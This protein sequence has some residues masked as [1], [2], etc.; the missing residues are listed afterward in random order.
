MPGSIR[1][2]IAGRRPSASTRAR[3]AAVSAAHRS[4]VA[5]GQLRRFLRLPLGVQLLG[6]AVAGV[7]AVLR[8]QALG[9]R[10][11][12]AR[13]RSI[14]R[15]GPNGPR[16]AQPAS[17]RALVPVEPQPVE[18]ARG[19]PLE[20]ERGAGHV[21]VLQAEDEGP[22]GVPGEQVVEER[23]PGGP[24]VE[25]PGGARARCG[26]AEWSCARLYGCH[27]GRPVTG[28]RG[29]PPCLR[30]RGPSAG[31][32]PAGNPVE[33][34]RVGLAAE[35]ADER[36]RP[37]AERRPPDRPVERHRVQRC[38]AGQDRRCELPASGARASRYDRSAGSSSAV[39][40]IR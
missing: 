9:G 20:L 35:D 12:R 1:N 34:R 13:R 38:G 17:G 11:R 25:R 32:K 14:W 5:R 22:A 40:V 15:Y 33:E 18:A 4:D 8:E 21:R 6:R 24:D 39:S 36:R 23:R 30:G 31:S 19:C 37:Q 3:S 29:R 27:P 26:H 16:S 10:P 28:R 2:R 7:G